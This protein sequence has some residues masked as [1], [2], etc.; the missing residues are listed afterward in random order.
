MPHLELVPVPPV[1]QRAGVSQHYGK[2]V[3]LHNSTLDIPS[4]CMVGLL[5]PDGVG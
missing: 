5:G 3:A 2:T 1:A 4:R